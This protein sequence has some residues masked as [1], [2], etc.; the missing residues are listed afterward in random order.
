MQTAPFTRHGITYGIIYIFD[1]QFFRQLMAGSRGV[2]VRADHRRVHPEGPVIAF[3]DVAVNAQRVAHRRPGPIE[4]PTTLAL[5]DGL[6]RA[7]PGGQV[8]PR[9]PGA[10]PK[11]DP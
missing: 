2:L 6:P 5:V 4:G 10:F 8:P 1:G 3:G 9:D 11:Q 7:E